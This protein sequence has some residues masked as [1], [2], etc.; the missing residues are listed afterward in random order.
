[1][2]E[3]RSGNGLFHD[4]MFV[5]SENNASLERYIYKYVS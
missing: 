5:E 2:G 3:A 4:G 1:M